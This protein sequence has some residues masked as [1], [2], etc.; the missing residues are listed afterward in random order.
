MR[1]DFSSETMKARK[2]WLNSF[3]VKER[4]VNQRP[5]SRENILRNEG[6]IEL[7]SDEVKRREMLF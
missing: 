5:I 7:S 3:Q 4:I 1:A 2:K 6:K